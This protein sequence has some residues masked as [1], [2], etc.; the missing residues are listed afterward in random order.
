FKK[1][2]SIRD[3]CPLKNNESQFDT[4][5]NILASYLTSDDNT[6]DRLYA[7]IN[8][9]VKIINDNNLELDDKIKIYQSDKDDI[10]E[11]V[12]QENM[13][14]KE[15]QN[16]INKK[17][18]HITGNVRSSLITSE[19]NIK[20]KIEILEYNLNEI[21]KGIK[22]T[23]SINLY[24]FDDIT[25]DV[26]RRMITCWNDEKSNLES[27]LLDIITEVIDEIDESKNIEDDIMK[28][29]HNE[30]SIET[31]NV[32]NPQFKFE[33][34]EKLDYEIKKSKKQYEQLRQ[35]MIVLDKANKSREELIDQLEYTRNSIKHLENQKDI[36]ITSLGT[37]EKQ[38]YSKSVKTKESRGG[39][40]GG[41]GN[42]LFGKKDTFIEEDFVDDT[43]YKQV[44]KEKDTLNKEYNAKI[45]SE[46]N[47]FNS[48][49]E[50]LDKIGA[51]DIDRNAKKEYLIDAREKYA[52]EVSNSDIK[53]EVMEQE[54]I[55]LGKNQYKNEILDHLDFFTNEITTHLRNSKD[56]II[57][58]MSQALKNDIEKLEK[59]KENIYN[60]NDLTS[61]NP[62][63][64]NRNI[65][66]AYSIINK[67]SDSIS[68]L[69][70]IKE[71]I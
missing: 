52:R 4:F 59:H 24:D 67:N 6:K 58:V 38:K 69:I 55:T 45:A 7:P 54:I 25:K 36:K 2:E 21:L 11:K 53:K 19:K 43:R 29:I 41:I 31:I 37:P 3:N 49:K 57:T 10:T 22:S 32:K 71:E 9:I 35:D 13:I 28:I 46:N 42:F 12:K 15:L 33:E 40:L 48:L 16:E 44:I 14:I 34:L 1:K 26:S 64:I 27:K 20:N 56:Y 68:K 50:K 39:L 5:S 17:K 70:K 63:I 60:L 61:S 51:I 62:D 30:F 23:F 66:E 8:R 47:N 65:T 18:K